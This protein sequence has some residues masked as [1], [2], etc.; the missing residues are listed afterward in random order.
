[1]IAST[2][3]NV[4]DR[5]NC[6]VSVVMPVFNEVVILQQL[7]DCVRTALHGNCASF[8]IVYVNDGSSDGSRECVDRL[9]AE[10]ARIVVVHLAR[11]FGHQAAVHAG[12]IHAR[13]DVVILMDSDLQD[14]PAA[15][16]GFLT[17]WEN[18]FDVVYSQR[19]NRK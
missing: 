1:M 14:D 5:Q 4:R 19:F 12:L 9:A 2:S 18:G 15:I 6:C 8:E 16:P 3:L 17:E 13:G 10:D 11:N 7:T